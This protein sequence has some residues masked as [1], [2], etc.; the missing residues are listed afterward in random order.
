MNIIEFYFDLGSPFSYLGFHRVQKIAKQYHAEVMYKPM[1]LGA[2]FKAT[3]NSS[4]IMVPAKGQYSL[5]DLQRW[6]NYLNIP[7]RM[8]PNF[9]I[10]TLPLMRIVT[11]VQLFLPEQFLQILTGLFDAM[12]KHPRNLNDQK[13]FIHVL[14]KLG[15]EYEQIKIW[16]E[17]EKVKSELKFI[18]EEAISRGVFGAPSFFVKDEL[19][20]GVD[21]LHFVELAMENNELPL[22]DQ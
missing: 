14:T 6:S 3:G 15:L 13:D 16:L 22:P 10:N 11:A 2:V 5:I 1:L 4:P 9:P 18:T 7:F 17:D 8:N 12:F 19:F 20:W 21:H